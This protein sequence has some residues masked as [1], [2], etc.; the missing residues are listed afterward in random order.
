[1]YEQGERKT[2]SNRPVSCRDRRKLRFSL[3]PCHALWL[4]YSPFSFPFTTL[5]VRRRTATLRAHIRI[6]RPQPGLVRV[7]M[8]RRALATHHAHTPFAFHFS[9]SS[10]LFVLV[11]AALRHRAYAPTRY[12]RTASLRS[13]GWA[14]PGC[15]ALCVERW[16]TAAYLW[17]RRPASCPAVCVF[18][19]QCSMAVLRGRCCCW[20]CVVLSHASPPPPLFC[21]TQASRLHSQAPSDT[22]KS[23]N[24]SN[25]SGTVDERRLTRNT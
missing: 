7:R 15:E 14:A 25:A 21:A 2:N 11:L 6:Q 1:M 12:R 4:F 22:A 24:R 20:N 5:V 16:W 3:G 13:T 23:N 9:R 18:A 10:H 19:V 17:C 8:D